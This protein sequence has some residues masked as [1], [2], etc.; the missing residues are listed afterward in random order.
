MTSPEEAWIGSASR[1]A[2]LA[3]PV[4]DL[5]RA[6]LRRF[7]DTGTAPTL[8]WLRQ[9]A[10]ELG[11]GDSAVAELE[12]ADLVRCWASGFPAHGW[13][14]CLA[15]TICCR[16]GPPRPSTACSPA[17]WT[18][19]SGDRP[20]VSTWSSRSRRPD[21]AAHRAGAGE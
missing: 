15:P 5:H 20:V 17:S 2:G 21:A 14:S 4:R 10:R 3:A 12:A 19:S 7:L 18:A 1:Q 13:R 11:N 16:C 9:A 8:D 6:V